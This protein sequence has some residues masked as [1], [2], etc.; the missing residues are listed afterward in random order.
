LIAAHAMIGTIDIREIEEVKMNDQGIQLVRKIYKDMNIDEEWSIITKRGFTWWGHQYAQRIWA[1]P[2][3]DYDGLLVTKVTVETDLFKYPTRSIETETLLA[4]EMLRA[5]L[6]GLV[7]NQETGR[8]KLRC[9]AY[10]HEENHNWLGKILSIAAIMQVVEAESRA[11]ILAMLLELQPDKSNHP[12]S[13]VRNEVDGLLGFVAQAVIP[14]GNRPFHTIGNFEFRRTADILNSQNLLSTADETG[15]TAYAP[16]AGNTAL[17]QVDTEQEHP[18]FG[19]GLLI[20]LSLPP[21]RIDSIKAG[22]LIMDMNSKVQNSPP[23]GHFLG[24]WCLGPVGKNVQTLVYV[25]FIPAIV[26]K[27]GILYNM[28]VSTLCHG[29]WAEGYFGLDMN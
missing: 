1:E 2:P 12:D 25:T 29:K 4:N 26:C 9:N 27:P 14:E 13:G 19:K 15:L 16:F 24:S 21:G 17:L 23:S 28:C 3:I 10:V 20:R 5:S 7:I 22:R 11:D 18:D 6:S 8:I